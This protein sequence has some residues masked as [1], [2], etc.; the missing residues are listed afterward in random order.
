MRT[1]LLTGPGGAG[2]STLAAAAAVRAARAGRRTLL[3]S[4]QAAAGRRAW[5]TSPGLDVVRVD[6]PGD[7]RAAVGRHGR[8]RWAPSCPHLTLPPASSVVPLPGT[9]E[10]AL[11]AELG[12]AP[13][14]TSSCWTPDRWR[15]MAALVALP[16]RA[17]LVARPAAAARACGRWAPSAPPP[18]RPAPPGAG[19]S[20]RRSPPCPVVEGLL[21]R[22]RLADRPRP[23][24]AWSPSRARTP[25]PAAARGGDRRWRCTACAPARCSP[26]CCPPAARGSGGPSGGR[27]AGR[28]S[29]P[30]SPRWR[31]VRRVPEHAVAAGRRRRPGRAA[32]RLRPARGAVRPATPRAPSGTTAPGS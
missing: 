20:T 8:R 24:S 25:S 32:R 13:R 15:P 21:A 2:T 16:A 3:L 7:R 22:D 27:R 9:G 10:L 12:A 17:A 14:P 26:G 29:S 30:G 6:P 1:L 28:P 4:R 23:P 5:T 19:R 31:P 18:S 11:F